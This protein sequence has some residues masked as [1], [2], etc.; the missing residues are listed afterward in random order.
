MRRTNLRDN[1]PKGRFPIRRNWRQILKVSALFLV[2]I[3]PGLTKVAAQTAPAETNAAAPLAGVHRVVF[4]GDSITYAGRY[5]DDIEAY[6]TT[7]FPH[8]HFEFLN[9]GLPSETVSG[10]SEPGHAGGKFPRPDLHWRLAS[11]LQ[12]TKPDLVFACYGMND[13]IYLPFDAER[14]QKFKDGME[15][16][17]AQ[18]VAAGARIIHVTPPVFDSVTAQ[19]LKKARGRDP[20]APPFAGYNAVLDRYAGWLMSE[21]TNGWRVVD[22]HGPMNQWLARHRRENPGFSYTREGIHPDAAGHWIMAR[23]ILL[24]LGAQEVGNEAS[25]TAMLAGQPQGGEILKLI[26]Q[27]QTLLKNAWLTK[28]GYQ[29]PGIPQGLPVE[30]ARLRADA[31]DKRINALVLAAAGE[32]KARTSKIAKAGVVPEAK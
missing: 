20:S 10:L 22:V 1:Q 25:V 5:V 32:T 11:I 26:R 19:Q 21:R 28:T 4:L 18:V 14:F 24:Y 2:L 16:L 13:G 23:Q 6:Y 12:Q 7:R 29:R 30:T 3:A 9:L 15:W 31:L 27:K 17:H 8:R